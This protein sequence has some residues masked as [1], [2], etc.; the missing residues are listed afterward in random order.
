MAKDGYIK[1]AANVYDTTSPYVWDGVDPFTTVISTDASNGYASKTSSW[2]KDTSK[3]L[4]MD[5]DEYPTGVSFSSGQFGGPINNGQIEV[6]L[7]D[8]NDDNVYYSL[9]TRNASGRTQSTTIPTAGGQP[10]YDYHWD[11]FS[12][13]STSGVQNWINLKGKTLALRKRIDTSPYDDISIQGTVKM[14]FNTTTTSETVTLISDTGASLTF[15]DNGSTTKA[16]GR[17][18][19]AQIFVSVAEGYRLTGITASYGNAP[20]KVS[21]TLYTFT[22]P[23]PAKPVTLVAAVERIPYYVTVNAYPDKTGTVTVSNSEPFFGETVQVTQRPAA[24][25]EFSGFGR[26]DGGDITDA[27]VFTMPSHNVT[28]TA[29][30]DGSL[31]TLHRNTN[32]ES[33]GVI[34]VPSATKIAT[35]ERVEV[36]E[37]HYYGWNIDGLFLNGEQLNS[38][39]F[40]M[41]PATSVLTV[42]YYRRI[43]DVTISK[44][45]PAAPNP[46]LPTGHVANSSDH[47]YEFGSSITVDAQSDG[48]EY[49]LIDCVITLQDQAEE[50][51]LRSALAAEQANLLG[52]P[53]GS[54]QWSIGTTNVSTLNAMIDNINTYV[55][56]APQQN[57][58]GNV[59]FTMPPANIHVEAIYEFHRIDW[60]RTPTLDIAQ[61]EYTLTFTR[62]GEAVDTLGRA[63]DYYIY[64][65]NKQYLKFASGQYTAACVL[66]DA[67]IEKTHE[68]TLMARYQNVS[69]DTTIL[70]PGVSVNFTT[71]P[72]HKTIGYY[73]NG[74]F[75]ECIPYYYDG[76]EFH[77]V[78]PHYYTGT[79]FE[80]CSADGSMVH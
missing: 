50:S 62:G 22:M 41:P 8:A 3:V 26:D 71:A 30:Y 32:P 76:N 39:T 53:N 35:A 49:K 57:S 47:K 27:G 61:N 14:S 28:V 6:V 11:N 5:Y 15:Q 69:T 1:S 9:G 72:V 34:Y 13:F 79:R 29:Y 58:T 38:Y 7:C 56:P 48:T 78:E 4:T 75:V 33:A 44:N 10:N 63:F 68:Y 43:Y 19:S 70:S 25:Y 31:Q 54:A 36:H 16:M 12:T 80:L 17:N 65:D 37:K 2:P 66:S 46:K 42:N 55:S 18:T 67:D 73:V 52:Y 20:S 64:R 51:V 40:Y 23:A 24:G 60:P 77:E 21:N 59:V 45:I 74:E